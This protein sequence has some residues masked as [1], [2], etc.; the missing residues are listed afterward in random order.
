MIKIHNLYFSYNNK[1]LL[2]NINI[3]LKNNTLFW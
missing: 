3:H 1:E 2:K